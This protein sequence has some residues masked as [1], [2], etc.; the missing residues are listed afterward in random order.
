MTCLNIVIKILVNLDIL[1]NPNYR[2]YWQVV[3]P[4]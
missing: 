1:Y 3:V 2:R 4:V